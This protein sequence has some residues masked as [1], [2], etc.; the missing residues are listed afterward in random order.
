MNKDQIAILSPLQVEQKLQR[1]ARELIE[2]HY[3]KDE[4][5]IIGISDRGVK[6]ATKIYDI[7][8]QIS[9]LKLSFLKLTLNKDIPNSSAI[10]LSGSKKELENKCVVL[11][12]DVLN[13]GKTLI[14]AA[15]FLLEEN[16]SQLNTV[17]LVDRRHRLFPIRADFVGLTLSTTLK[18]HISVVEVSENQFEVYLN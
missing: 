10:E 2:L 15:S 12:D 11:I 4:I 7:L 8:S 14:H 5:V 6:I 3:N 17:V 9:Q 1:I 18:E 13:S 16:I